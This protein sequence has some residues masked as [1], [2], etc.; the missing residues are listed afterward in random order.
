MWRFTCIFLS[1]IAEHLN[2]LSFLNWLLFVLIPNAAVREA[3]PRLSIAWKYLEPISRY[4]LNPAALRT[5]SI[6]HVVQRLC[7]GT[8]SCKTFSLAFCSNTAKLDLP[9]G[10][11]SGP[12]VLTLDP[13][14]LGCR[15][16]SDMAKKGLNYIP[17]PPT[18]LDDCTNQLLSIGRDLLKKL[19]Y[20]HPKDDGWCDDDRL[21]ALLDQWCTTQFSLR[22]ASRTNL[23]NALHLEPNMLSRAS[24]AELDRIQTKLYICEADK[25]PHQPVFICRDFAIFTIYTRLNSADFTRLSDTN[26]D[27]LL[28]GLINDQTQIFSLQYTNRMTIAKKLLTMRSSFKAH[29]QSFRFIT[30]GSDYVLTP[31]DKAVQLMSA[32]L[33]RELEKWAGRQREKY[34]R[35]PGVH[36]QLFPIIKDYTEC[37]FNLPPV[38]SSDFTAD[39]ARCFEA[40][41]TC[42]DRADGL[43][44]ALR[45]LVD[46]VFDDLASQSRQGA[47]NAFRV[48]FGRSDVLPAKCEISHRLVDSAAT[49]FFSR[50]QYLRMSALIL[51]GA[52][53]S[54]GGVMYL[55]RAGIPMGLRSS[56]DWCNLYLLHKEITAVQRIMRYDNFELQRTKL[57]AFNFFF[58]SMDDLRVI[59]G[60]PLVDMILFKGQKTDASPQWI[61]PDC[62]GI[63]LTSVEG[64]NGLESTCFL[65]ILTC[66]KV[67]VTP[68]SPRNPNCHSNPYSLLIPTVTGPQ[69]HAIMWPSGSHYMPFYMP[70]VRSWQ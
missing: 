14:V 6:N 38:L 43:L 4:F 67:S 59:N 18:N 28:Q 11:N 2:P 69:L 8:C 62:L 19:Q 32:A 31:T 40:I 63:D 44:A 13:N 56:P 17:I 50:A 23:A 26:V 33:L 27:Q 36:T 45:F 3:L 54:A 61:Y 25:A 21:L 41:P 68:R 10:Y 22:G 58:R 30:N 24:L 60:Q 48:V 20:L 53:T 34:L 9:N 51:R 57:A 47:T 46:L 15:E 64:P 55:Q 49:K 16:L 65:D 52:V 35:W 29:K 42:V 39:V 7:T 1:P 37:L 5:F 12:H 66:F 70:P